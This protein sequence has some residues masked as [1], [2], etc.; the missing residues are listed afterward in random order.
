MNT[1]LSVRHKFR[2]R[3]VRLSISLE[4]FSVVCAAILVT[5]L[6]CNTNG[7]WTSSNYTFGKKLLIIK[8]MPRQQ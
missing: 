7:S 6:D 8:R 4:P 3:K 5:H 2:L 1:V